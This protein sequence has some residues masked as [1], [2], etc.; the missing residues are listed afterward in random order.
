MF[1]P[2]FPTLKILNSI[3]IGPT[4]ESVIKRL[5]TF[6]ICFCSYFVKKLE[7]E[8]SI[9]SLSEK[10]FKY[11]TSFDSSCFSRYLRAGFK[12]SSVNGLWITH[13]VDIIVAKPFA[14]FSFLNLI[15]TNKFPFG[16]PVSLNLNST[17]SFS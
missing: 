16:L 15:G 14:P 12:I 6:S 1:F 9:K 7:I 17:T 11:P 13:I 10:I 8:Q 4:L 5:Y 3:S 2:F